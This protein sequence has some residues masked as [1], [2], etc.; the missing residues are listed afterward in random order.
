MAHISLD[1]ELPGILGLFK[2]RPE[3]AKALSLLAETLLRGESP[4]SS[5]DRESI[6]A[7]V[8]RGNNC[9]FCYSS[10]AAAARAH[11]GADAAIFD[12]MIRDPESSSVSPKLKALLRIADKVRQ[13]GSQVAEADIALAKKEG[14]SDVE[15]HDTILIAAAF[16]MFNRYVDGA[17]TEA[18]ESP[19]AYVEMG[20]MLA[21]VGYV[22]DR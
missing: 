14:T 21:D 1:L 22:Q 13:G 19:A 4:L 8:S 9:H 3:S 6:A 10:H 7:Y 2:F 20:R 11:L 18:P 5:A 17:G 16:C 12:E 15:I